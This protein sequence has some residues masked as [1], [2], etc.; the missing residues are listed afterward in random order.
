MIEID[1][2]QT[3]KHHDEAKRQR[4]QQNAGGFRH[5]RGFLEEVELEEVR[6]RST[7]PRPLIGTRRHAEAAES[8]VGPGREAS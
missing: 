5:R 6:V 7:P 4:Q 1:P 2:W 3:S 8:L